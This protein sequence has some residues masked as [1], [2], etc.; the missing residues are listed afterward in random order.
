MTDGQLHHDSSFAC[1]L[2]TARNS[3]M[4]LFVRSNFMHL[5]RQGPFKVVSYL[6]GHL[7]F[8]ISLF[9][10]IHLN[11]SIIVVCVNIITLTVN[12]LWYLKLNKR[13][14]NDTM[15]KIYIFFLFW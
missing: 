3:E 14:H 15:L 11:Y 2:K 9:S 7:S 13:R 8:R 5:P 1:V 6:A 12:V 4:F 10:T